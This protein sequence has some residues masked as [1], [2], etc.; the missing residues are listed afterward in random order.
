M[1]V[2]EEEDEVE[3]EEG[4]EEEE[5]EGA[6]GAGVAVTTGVGSELARDVAPMGVAQGG[7]DCVLRSNRCET[8]TLSRIQCSSEKKE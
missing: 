6:D 3:E 2:E 1:V 7:I 8:S 5:E 4:G